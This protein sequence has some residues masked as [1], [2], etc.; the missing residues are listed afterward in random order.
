MSRRRWVIA[1]TVVALVG[2]GGS[3]AFALTRGSSATPSATTTTVT[4]T[5]GTVQS[6]VTTTGTIQP[7]Q[8][9][10][11]TFD[12]S[13]TVS[14]V[15]ATVGQQVAKGAVLATVDSTTL[16]SAVTTAAAAVTAAE[17]E[18][19]AVAGGSD[20]QVAS[21]KAQ[22]AAARTELA[23]AQ[24]ALASASLTAPFAGTVAAVTMAVGDVIGGQ[25][26]QG[27][28]T[29]S[30]TLISSDA[31]VV[32]ASVGS[33]DLAQLKK[34]MQAQITPSGAT[35]RVFGTVASIGIVADSTGTTA[36]FPVVIAVTGS[37]TGLY[38]G[39]SADV[40]IIVKQLANVLTV[41]TPAVTTVDGQTVV[42]R[43]VR[44]KRERTVVTLGDSYGASTVVT[45]GL[46]DGD[47]VEVTFARPTGVRRSGGQNNGNVG[48]PGG[49]TQQFGGPG[50]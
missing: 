16:R 11:L 29:P 31:W 44:G 12:V 3:A 15:A 49:F 17:Q 26:A 33:S 14:R 46:K 18:V 20:V 8:D 32:N 24:A 43:L 27:S 5:K 1:S 41:P 7:K 40:S 36:T 50:K 6:T 4:V 48:P 10:D 42:Y 13:G 19:A 38:A 37:P 30:I 39:G 35:Q 22:L 23:N 2:G 21:A 9:Q 25:G 34:G 45:S 28:S 47:Q